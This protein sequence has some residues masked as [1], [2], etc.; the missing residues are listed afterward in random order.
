MLN[1]SFEKWELP[2]VNVVL[3]VWTQK[4]YCHSTVVKSWATQ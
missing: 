4:H 2:L 1:P 3:N